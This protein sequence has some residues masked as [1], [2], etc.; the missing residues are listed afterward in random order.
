MYPHNYAFSNSLHEFKIKVGGGLIIVYQLDLYQR[1]IVNVRLTLG[2]GKFDDLFS[3]IV[4]K[5][6]D[7]WIANYF[8]EDCSEDFE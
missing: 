7:S 5:A 4:G 6:D 2:G 3:E 8:G 1:W